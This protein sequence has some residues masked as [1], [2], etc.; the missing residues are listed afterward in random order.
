MT[1]EGRATPRQKPRRNAIPAS[2]LRGRRLHPYLNFDEKTRFAAV[3]ITTY[4]DGGKLDYALVTSS[5]ER[6]ALKHVK[7]HLTTRPLRYE[8]L[9]DRWAPD[10]VAR[11]VTG[12]DAPPSFATALSMLIEVVDELCEFSSDA[13]QQERC[14]ATMATWIL[15][16]YVHVALPAL[17]RLNFRG[18]PDAG[19]SKSLELIAHT[20][21]NGFL[22]L[23]PSAANV[24]RLIEPLRP[25]LC[26][27]E[28]EDI[29][30]SNRN[31]KADLRKLVN[32]GYRRG[33]VV[34]RCGQAD[35]AVQFFSAYAPLALGSIAG[36]DHVTRTRA[37]E[38]AMLPG[39]SERTTRR[40][41]AADER[42]AAIRDLG[43]RL[44][45]LRPGDVADAFAMVAMPDGI[46]RRKREL[47]Q[48]LLAIAT[49]ADAEDGTLGL[50]PI[51]AEEARRHAA[52]P[53]GV[54]EWEHELLT[55]LDT[56]LGERPHVDVT[57][58]DLAKSLL[59]ATGECVSPTRVGVAL[60]SFGF[61]KRQRTGEARG[62][63]ITRAV[64]DRYRSQNGSGQATGEGAPSSSG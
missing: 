26:I 28:S 61:E 64:L 10:A 53:G 9:A 29:A 45:L 17:P 7:R 48:P 1:A 51:L 19:K 32:A 58:T 42:L 13:K 6:L 21:F 40:V 39:A 50:W 30:S 60:A 34:P 24:F 33:G 23:D 41:N 18:R 31:Y 25:A 14:A 36:L 35:Y 63:R 47:W 43:Y 46:A 5:R 54:E 15:A 4:S 8:Q 59:D 20:A 62:W 57:A 2:S 55:I 38:F 3:G 12:K 22:L 37:I 52:Q 27:D 44:A 11:F 56:M 16:T 49:L